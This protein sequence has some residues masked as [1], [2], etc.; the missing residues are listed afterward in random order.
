MTLLQWDGDDNFLYYF[1][2]LGSSIKG[3]MQYIKHVIAVDD[4]HL[5]GLYRGSMFVA[6]CL[7]DNNQLYPLAIGVIDSQNNNAWEWF[8]TKLHGVIGDRPELLFISDRCTAIKRAVLKPFHTAGHGV[9][10]YYVKGNIKSKFKM[11][12][13]I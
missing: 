5:K 10:F 4:T 7:D 8:M 1:V 11:S 6:T 2:A 9:C 12:K 3:F 13:V